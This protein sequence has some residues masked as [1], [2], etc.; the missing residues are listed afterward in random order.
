MPVAVF[1][2]EEL[3]EMNEPV[4]VGGRNGVIVGVNRIGSAGVLRVL[5]DDSGTEEEVDPD[6]LGLQVRVP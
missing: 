6:D 1:R 3:V 2:G 4:T 5:F